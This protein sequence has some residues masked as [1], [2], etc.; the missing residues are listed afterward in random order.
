MLPSRPRS[1]PRG[2]PSEPG[3]ALNSCS[4]FTTQPS[5]RSRPTALRWLVFAKTKPKR[6]AFTVGISNTDFFIPPYRDNVAAGSSWV[7]P[8]GPAG[9]RFLTCISAASTSITVTKPGEPPK[10][11]LSVPAYDFSWQ[12]LLRFL[13]TDPV[14][15]GDS[16]RLSRP[17]R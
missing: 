12:D 14:T 2:P 16:N 10:V 3:S 11:V 9:R 5:A 15:Q 13:R 17:F 4:R 7:L 6:E 8:E 1:S